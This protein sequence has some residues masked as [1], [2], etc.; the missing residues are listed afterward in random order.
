V[1]LPAF[2]KGPGTLVDFRCRIQ[3]KERPTANSIG[4]DRE[5]FRVQLSKPM[6]ALEGFRISLLAWS[7]CEPLKLKFRKTRIG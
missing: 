4:P 7:P 6:M 5:D 3:D 1:L 2:T